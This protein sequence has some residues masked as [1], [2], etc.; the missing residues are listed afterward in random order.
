LRR[1]EISVVLVRIGAEGFDLSLVVVCVSCKWDFIGCG[2]V[3][4]GYQDCGLA[5]VTGRFTI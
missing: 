4:W 3:K 2:E 1:R 5:C